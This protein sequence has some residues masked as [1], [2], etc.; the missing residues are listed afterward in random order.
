MRLLCQLSAH[1]VSFAVG[2]QVGQS[3]EA[4]VVLGEA[5]EAQA[6]GGNALLCQEL[7]LLLQVCGE[8]V[9]KLR[10]IISTRVRFLF[11]VPLR[12]LGDGSFEGIARSRLRIH[13]QFLASRLSRIV[14]F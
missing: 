5:A 12:G 3:V 10:R 13:Q 9:R 2:V 6:E 14:R 11:A 8:T 7:A 4:L 1:L